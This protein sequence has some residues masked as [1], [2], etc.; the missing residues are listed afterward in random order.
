M[1][2]LW[3]CPPQAIYYSNLEQLSTILEY[4]LLQIGGVIFVEFA[5][6]LKYAMDKAELTN[7]ALAK[8][9]KI[10]QSTIANWL[11]EA[12]VP[13]KKK[14]EMVLSVFGVTKEDL[15]SDAPVIVYRDEE[16]ETPTVLEDDERSYDDA[17][18]LDAFNKADETTKELIRRA[19]GLK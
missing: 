3:F 6:F 4:H 1:V 17:V 9:L 11:S 19:L 2:V 8:R 15:L 10:S 5:E 13:S 14:Q 16:K 12:T 7:Y 18:L